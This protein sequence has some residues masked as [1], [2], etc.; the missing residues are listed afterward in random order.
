MWVSGGRH[1]TNVTPWKRNVGKTFNIFCSFSG[2]FTKFQK[3]TISFAMHACLSVRPHGT[4]V[5]PLDR[6]SQY[7]ILKI[8]WKSLKKF[9]VLSKSDKNNVMP[10]CLSVRPSAWN[11]SSPTERIFT[12][13]DIWWFIWKS[14]EKFRVLS[15]SDKNNGHFTWRLTY[16]YVPLW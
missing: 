2:T 12:K 5:L 9:R 4:I 8:F 1:W 7:L 16:V 10:V 3:A 15:R 14:L 11:N 13:F 6:F